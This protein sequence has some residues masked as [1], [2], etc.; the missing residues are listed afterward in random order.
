MIKTS[1]KALL[2]CAVLSVATL[3][4]SAQTKPPACSP[5]GKTYGPLVVSSVAGCPF[6]AVVEV[7]NAQTLGDGSHIVTKY[8]ALSYRDSAGR[9]GY[10]SFTVTDTFND[11]SETPKMIQTYDPIAGFV[12]M[13]LLDRSAAWRSKLP[14][15]A[16]SDLPRRALSAEAAASSSSP[17]PRVKVVVEDLGA[18]QMQGVLVFGS[19][20]IRTIPAG[21]EGNDRELT[22]I[23]ESWYS[24]DLGFAL[25]Q[26][27][28]DPRSKDKGMRVTSLDL[29]EPDPTLFQVPAG[30]TIIDQ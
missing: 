7:T 4:G 17:D 1:L 13:I 18:Q 27:T 2:L 26:K 29:S 22:V 5:P 24:R 30:Y 11:V 9:V 23:S 3:T 20:S 15:P 16:V 12:N 28:V 21:V 10:Q 8:K 19:K 14:A 6:S 25:L